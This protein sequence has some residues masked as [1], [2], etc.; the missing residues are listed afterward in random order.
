MMRSRFS[1]LVLSLATIAIVARPAAQEGP[2]PGSD[3]DAF[4]APYDRLLDL[5]VRDGLVYY[6]ALKSDRGRFDRYLASLD[7][8]PAAYEKWSRDRR[9]SYWINAYNAFMLQTIIDRYPI[10]GS[11]PQYPANSVRQISGAFDK[12]PH[13]A[14]GKTLTLDEIEK[15]MISA[16]EEPRAFLALGRGSVGGGRLLSEAFTNE[17]LEK[18]L[19]ELAAECVSRQECARIDVAAATIAVTPVFSWRQ[20]EFIKAY[21]QKELPAYPDRSPIERAVM[22]L[23]GPHLLPREK[24]ALAKNDFTVSFQPYDWRLNDLTGGPPPR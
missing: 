13:R 2:A 4:H 9:L 21:G 22:F 17:R 14:A 15:T 16:F 11:A 23:L 5:Y 20:A 3:V 18:Q 10:R 7:V 19:E 24:M 6:R 8:A 12:L 1:A